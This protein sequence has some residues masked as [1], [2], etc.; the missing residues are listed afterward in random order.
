MRVSVD[1]HPVLRA[2]GRALWKITS[3]PVLGAIFLL[4]PVVY[5]VC[6]LTFIGGIVA[7]ILFEISAVGPRFPFIQIVGIASLFGLFAALYYALV[8]FLIRD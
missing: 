2:S 5:W 1:N 6:G 3:F 7:A 8:A 4:A